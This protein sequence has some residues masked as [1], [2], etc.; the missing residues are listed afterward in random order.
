M[1]KFRC[2]FGIKAVILFHGVNKC[3]H[4]VNIKQRPDGRRHHVIF[5]FIGGKKILGK[6]IGKQFRRRYVNDISAFCTFSGKFQEIGIIIGI[7][8]N[9][10]SLQAQRDHL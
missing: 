10:I 3:A 9:K 7:P 6:I 2:L 5:S 8:A 1:E 4:A